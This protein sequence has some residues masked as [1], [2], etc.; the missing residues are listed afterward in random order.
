MSPEQIR[1]EPLDARTDLFSFG[2]VLYEM[3]K[4]RMAYPKDPSSVI[5][6][7]D[8]VATEAEGSAVDLP[9]AFERV[10]WRALERQRELRY[11]TAAEMKGDLERLKREGESGSN[12]GQGSSVV[13]GSES[14]SQI[15][16]AQGSGSTAAHPEIAAVSRKTTELAER[17][18]SRRKNAV[19]AFIVTLALVGACVWWI[20]NHI[21]P[22]PLSEHDTVVLADFDN[23]TADSVFD[24]TLKTALRIALDQSPFL[25]VMP[26]RKIA[27]ISNLMQRSPGAPLT[28]SVASEVCQRAG[29][30]A[31]IGGSISNLGNVYVLGLRA[32]NCQTGASLV[33]EQVTAPTKEKV[34]EALSDAAATLR[35]KLGESLATVQKFDVPLPA[36]T[37]SLDAL[38]SYSLGVKA[39]EEKGPAEA[40]PYDERAIQLDP[41]FAMAY[42]S[43]GWD[44][45][46]LGQISRASKYFSKAFELRERTS[47]A[48]S[49]VIASDYY[50][51]VTGELEKAAQAI[52]ERAAIYPK[53]LDHI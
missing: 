24:D 41:N 34:L 19:F 30:K 10:L 52:R 50:L 17:K 45:Q 36:T 26:D 37:R 25:N 3:A 32:V 8:V 6:A 16:T 14:S 15:V 18:G 1:G 51:V 42:W 43:L 13:S 33:E 47:E 35:H 12:S 53:A 21:I 5:L 20:S 9:I 27:E 23:S 40:I 11:Q 29:G 22:P 2:A 39:N 7:R 44:Y 38:K 28:T 31:Y 49:L 48:E 46:N 4:G